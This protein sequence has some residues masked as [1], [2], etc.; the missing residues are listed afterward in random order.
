MY[1]VILHNFHEIFYSLLFLGEAF[2]FR[3][4]YGLLVFTS[5]NTIVSLDALFFAI[6]ILTMMQCGN[7]KNLLVSMFVP[8]MH[9]RGKS[10]SGI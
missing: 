1:T 2:K 5:Q 7:C 3:I 10:R 9:T 6:D 8:V 4:Q